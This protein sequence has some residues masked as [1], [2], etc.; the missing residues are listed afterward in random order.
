M[1]VRMMPPP[2]QENWRGRVLGREHADRMQDARDDEQHEQHAHKRRAAAVALVESD[3]NQRDRH[4]F[5]K[6]GVAAHPPHQRIIA[7]VAEQRLLAD[8]ADDDPRSEADID[9]R[10]QRGVEGGD[11]G[12]HAAVLVNASD[13][14]AHGEELVGARRLQALAVQRGE[15]AQRGLD[16]VAGRLEAPGGVAV[17]AP[18][19]A[20]RRSNR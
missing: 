19:S 3:D 17:R 13:L 9:Q 1:S 5:D 8:T 16:R 4:V 2:R 12:K 15:V 14:P 11:G 7:A 20:R 6:V 18:P 10:E